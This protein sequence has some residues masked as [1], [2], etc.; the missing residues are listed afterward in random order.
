MLEVEEF[1][2]VLEFWPN[3]SVDVFLASGDPVR[4]S[5]RPCLRVTTMSYSRVPK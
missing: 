4:T 2:E 1:W 3:Q 5:E